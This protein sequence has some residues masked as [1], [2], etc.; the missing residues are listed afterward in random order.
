MNIKSRIS[1]VIS[2]LCTVLLAL[3]GYNCSF[4]PKMMYGTPTGSFEVKG[5][6]TD[7]ENNPV[8]NAEITLRPVQRVY[9]YYEI[10]SV[11]SGSDG[12]FIINT[13]FEPLDSVWIACNPADY[14][15]LPE[16]VKMPVEY[17]YDKEHKKDAWYVGHAEITV[18]F[19]LHTNP[20][21]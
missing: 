9:G 4:E 7:K 18:N 8:K 10:A 1:K 11:T 12:K 2:H 19:E 6:V 17:H 20:D 14:T 3:L 5:R 21:K 13:S 15:Y 16:T